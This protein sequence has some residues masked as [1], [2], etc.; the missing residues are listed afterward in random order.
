MI[1]FFISFI[2]FLLLQKIN[3]EIYYKKAN[4]F[5]IGEAPGENEDNGAADWQTNYYTEIKELPNI[6]LRYES[7]M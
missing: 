5:L 1:Y 6:R 3:P 2:F 4:L 7:I